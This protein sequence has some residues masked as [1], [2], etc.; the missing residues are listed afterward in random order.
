[1]V[2]WAQ[3]LTSEV[4]ALWFA[5]HHPHTPFLAKAVAV[6]LV[7]YAFSPIDLIPDFIPVLGYLD[8]VIILPAGI[9]IVLRLIPA[10]VLA[11][12]RARG[13]QWLAERN[14][15]PKS[16]A[17]LALVVAIWIALAWLAWLWLEPKFS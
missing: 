6:A 16:Y 9:W 17:G 1:M 12:C 13:A 5:S 10:P 8:D 3:K 15:K 7:A 14:A 11:E 4:V 2:S